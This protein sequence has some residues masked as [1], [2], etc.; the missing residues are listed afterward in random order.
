MR[1]LVLL[2]ALLPFAA[3]A[4]RLDAVQLR[5]RM[6][7][8]FIEHGLP[9]QVGEWAQNAPGSGALTA[10]VTKNIRI[11]AQQSGAGEL[12][13]VVVVMQ[14]AG[15]WQTTLELV[16]TIAA[17]TFAAHPDLSVDERTLL[18]QSLGLFE[19]AW[20]LRG[21]DGAAEHDGVSW[22]LYHPPAD[23]V[24]VVILAWP[25]IEQPRST[26][27]KDTRAT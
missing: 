12:S 25:F 4:G 1:R 11:V 2:A 20:G 10:L 9:M 23:A 15:T 18:F 7:D 26:V 17:L 14:S 24:T 6:N 3:A 27:L 16:G 5:D 8:A 19:D 22:R 13:S 21:V